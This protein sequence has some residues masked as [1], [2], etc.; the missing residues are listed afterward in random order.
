MNNTNEANRLIFQRRNSA[1]LKFLE[2]LMV[3]H[4][5]HTWFISKPNPFHSMQLIPVHW[6]IH[7]MSNTPPNPVLITLKH[8]FPGFSF[9]PT[10]FLQSLNCNS[11]SGQITAQTPISLRVWKLRM[12]PYLPGVAHKNKVTIA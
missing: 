1:N 11:L 12:Q 9:L 3:K 7:V 6:C 8:H 4:T 2:G 10:F 5:S